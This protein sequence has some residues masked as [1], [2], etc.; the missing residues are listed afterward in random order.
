MSNLG[1]LTTTFSPPSSCLSSFSDLY[2]TLSGAALAVGPISTDGCFP[3]DFVPG[4]AHYYSPGVCPL[5]YTSACAYLNSIGS[6]TETI[7]TCCPTSLYCNTAP[8]H[9]WETQMICESAIT[10]LAGPFTVVNNGVTSS[11]VSMTFSNGGAVNAY[12]YVIRYQSTTATPG[13]TGA[14]TNPTTTPQQT[15]SIPTST[16]ASTSATIV[17]SSSGG[18]GSGAIAGIAVGSAAAALLMAGVVAWAYFLG[19]RSAMQRIQKESEAAGPIAPFSESTSGWGQSGTMHS[20]MVM[21]PQWPQE[22]S[23]WNGRSAEL[24][25]QMSPKSPGEL[26]GYIFD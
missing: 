2:Y 14:T 17:S 18:L 19:R 4:S 23:S 3:D 24:S 22:V 11:T 20:D 10:S 26:E 13:A 21:P 9:S 5:G 1:V 6:A 15:A 8:G 12:G 16:S 7:V 25:G